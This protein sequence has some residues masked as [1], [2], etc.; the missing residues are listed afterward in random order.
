MYDVITFG[1]ATRDL[2]L[3]SDQYSLI[4]DKSFASQEGLCVS[5]GSKIY[6]DDIMFASGGGGTNVAATFALQGLKTAHVGKVGNDSGGQAILNELEQRGI[7]AEMVK[8]DTKEKTAHSVVLS[9]TGIARTILVY[10]GAC[11]KM[12]KQ[13]I[14]WH[15]LKAEWFYVAPLSGLSANIFTD[16]ISFAEQNSIPVALNPGH[17][18]L[19]LGQKG[20]AKLFANLEVLIL[21]QEEGS[22][23]TGIEF[24][25]DEKILKKLK[26]WVKGKVVLTKGP[27]GILAAD[28]EYFYKA[29]IPSS[30]IVDRTGA[31]D[32]FGSGLVSKLIKGASFDEAIAY[33]TANATACVQQVGA[34]N[35]LLEKDQWGQWERV[36]VVKYKP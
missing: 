5:A 25:K 27:A 33:G 1:S 12:T 35:G 31:G 19:S 16:I 7:E 8:T 6:L 24:Q 21:N 4:K 28:N 9:K 14:P 34:K 18:Q 15:Q 23:I 29:G 2:F 22:Q 10:R 20:V 36:K 30:G 3:F 32:S 17:S 13:E 11:H 26:T